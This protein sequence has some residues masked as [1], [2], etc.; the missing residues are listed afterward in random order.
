MQGYPYKYDYDK[1]T[2]IGGLRWLQIGLVKK[3]NT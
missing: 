3:K 1:V 2:C